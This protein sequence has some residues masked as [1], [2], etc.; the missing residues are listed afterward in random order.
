MLRCSGR[1]I[2][3]EGASART[4]RSLRGGPAS[5]QRWWSLGLGIG[6]GM[7]WTPGDSLVRF[8]IGATLPVSYRLTADSD[9]STPASNWCFGVQH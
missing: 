3:S 2:V 1:V 8:G 4:L 7:F 5:A 6:P 9:E